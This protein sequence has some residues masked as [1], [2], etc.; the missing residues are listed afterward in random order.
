MRVGGGCDIAAKSAR[1]DW[2]KVGT[3]TALRAYSRRHSGDS[4]RSSTPRVIV[5]VSTA[6]ITP[7]CHGASGTPKE[8]AH[9]GADPAKLASSQLF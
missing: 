9:A 3:F 4:V 7:A 2:I 8:R 5:E 1:W 6:I